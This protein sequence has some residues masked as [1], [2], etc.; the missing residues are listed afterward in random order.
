MIRLIGGTARSGKSTL[1]RSLPLDARHD[2]LC[3][4]RLRWTVSSAVGLDEDIESPDR[5]PLTDEKYGPWRGKL[6][7]RENKVWALADR[8]AR[9][10]DFDGGDA[11]LCGTIRPDHI[12]LHPHPYDY[13][14][15]ILVDTGIAERALSIAR[16]YGDNNWQS[17]WSDED[18][19]RWADLNARM[20][21]TQVEMGKSL[22]VSVLDVA[23]I[24]YDEAQSQARSI[25]D[26]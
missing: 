21:R 7:D 4:D 5:M 15:V 13:L 24:G 11:I 22:G 25:L 10:V 2:I 6:A 26:L 17:S 12:G 19:L 3:L 23:E 9:A 16:G 20:A 14:G 8:Y 1:L 18:I